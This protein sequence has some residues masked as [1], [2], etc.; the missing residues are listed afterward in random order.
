MNRI[1]YDG[2]PRKGNLFSKRD[3]FRGSLSSRVSVTNPWE[4]F[5]ARENP[6][7]VFL[8]LGRENDSTS[9]LYYDRMRYWGSAWGYR[10]PSV[11]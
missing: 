4:N 8:I 3:Y 1:A 6:A 5:G 7:S 10:G 2:Y 11:F 9:G